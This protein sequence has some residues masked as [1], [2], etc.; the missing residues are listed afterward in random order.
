[1]QQLSLFSAVRLPY[2]PWCA[3]DL[4]GALL[5]KELVQA[6]SYRYIQLNNP[7]ALH[8]IVIDID[9]PII[10]DP[11]SRQM[12]AILDGDVPLPNFLAVNPENQHAHA[13]YAL[14]KAV[15]KGEHA[16]RK[17]LRFAAAIESALIFALGGDPLYNGL[18]A[19]NPVH[20]DWRLIDLRSAPYSL[21]ELEAGLDLA[22]P[23]KS[24]QREEAKNAGCTGRNVRVFDRLRFH[25]YQHV[26]MYRADS[27]FPTWRRYLAARADEYNRDETP[28]LHANELKHITDSVAGWTWD[29]YTGSL[30]DEAFSELQA[31]RGARG[32]RISARV[33]AEQ[34]E[35]EGYTLSDKMAAV[36]RTRVAKK[37][38]EAQGISK[39][40]YYRDR[41]S[42]AP[43][44]A[45][46]S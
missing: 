3:N 25:A 14:E 43:A 22:G 29:T 19:K 13:Y 24:T 21:H 12:S 45:P 33:R 35:K 30:S 20:S 40:K 10:T 36:S 39:A 34:A 9:A 27:N 44:P 18:I 37:P 5:M 1:M 4:P 38:W 32:G 41:K 7:S 2:R 11:V 15:P 26:M 42:G 28:P 17:A 16:S 23:D 6:L 46:K 8:W 31:F